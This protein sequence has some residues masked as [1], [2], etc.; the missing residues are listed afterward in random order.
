MN[1]ILCPVDYSNCSDYAL[2]LACRICNSSHSKMIV[3]AVTDPAKDESESRSMADAFANNAKAK[4]RDQM[5]EEKG[6][7]VEHLSLRGKPAEV[8]VQ[9][10]SAKHADAIVMG[11]H[12]RTGWSKLMLGSV[13]QEVM[14]TA[15]CPVITVRPKLEEGL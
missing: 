5:F 11:T 10:A 2:E 14:R 3:L 9:I 8:I 12:G 7:A 1:I 13:A 15:H 6:V 4:I